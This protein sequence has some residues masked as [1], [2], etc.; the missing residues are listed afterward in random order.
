[1]SDESDKWKRRYERERNARKQAEQLL[2]EKSLML[3]E[4]NVELE[5][6]SAQLAE[7]VERRTEELR[8]STSKLREQ[9]E[10]MSSLAETFPGV[11]FQWVER[12]NGESGFNYMSPRVEKI[13]GFSATN[14]IKDW[15]RMQIHYDDVPA[16]QESIKEAL[17]SMSEWRCTGRLVTPS[18]ETRWW[19]GYGKPLRVSETEVAFN[20]VFLDI[21]QQKQIEAQIRRLSLVASRTINGVVI[22]DENGRVVWI[23]EA[24]ERITGY[25]LQEL[26]GRKPGELLQGPL[27]CRKTIKYI[28]ERLKEKQPLT[29]ELLNYH[30][31]GETYWLRLDVNPL[32]DEKNQLTN[33]VGIE[34]DIT[35]QKETET[36]LKLASEHAQEAAKEANRAN[37]AKSRFLASMSHEIR[38]PLN[39]VLGYTQVLN[40]RDDLPEDAAGMIESIGR[41]GE[42]L[43]HLINDILDISK[44]EAGKYELTGGDVLLQEILRDLLDMFSPNAELKS[45]RYDCVCWDFERDTPLADDNFY[46]QADA[47]ALRQILLNL[48]GNAIKFTKRGH[49]LV[50]AGP[51]SASSL[52]FIVEDT[53]AGIPEEDHQRIF[54]TFEQSNQT[55]SKVAG[56]GLGL[57]ICR[58]LVGLMEGSMRLES[59][60]GKGSRFS[61][62]I[63]YIKPKEIH[64]TYVPV[65]KLQKVHYVGP[66]KDILVVDDDEHS[67]R[68]TKELL[69]A[70]GFRVTS[71]SSGEDALHHLSREIPDLVAT[72]LLMPEIDGFELRHRIRVTPAIQHLPV[73]AVSASVMQSAENAS[74]LKPFAGFIAKPVKAEDLY[75]QVGEVLGLEWQTPKSEEEQPDDTEISPSPPLEKSI[76]DRPVLQSLLVL[77][78]QGDMFGLQSQIAEIREDSQEHSEFYTQLHD[79][80]ASFQSQAIE[81]LLNDCLANHKA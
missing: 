23:N 67:R 45:I 5:K 11:I 41:S 72:D 21:S 4:K 10:R 37:Q 58:K 62:D 61:F 43:L 65:Q 16:W 9:E 18:G 27:T 6:L 3:Y 31:N 24:F 32:F 68:V 48:V 75:R 80:A 49:V 38:T 46:F 55:N 20:G 25:T 64:S 56:T 1:M 33:F 79:L 42:H 47:R 70:A 29:A 22:T 77:A 30:K 54:E 51:D 40:M 14:A 81:D 44:I 66:K 8:F 57:P 2:E 26:R 76:P 39:G 50:K 36:A 63:P 78:E 13:F 15:H 60:V 59:E 52:K 12:S 17:Q 28:G 7:T 73:I 35:K 74:R 53:G 71:V 19:Q 69:I 34:T